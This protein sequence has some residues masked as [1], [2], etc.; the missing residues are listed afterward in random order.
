[1]T[2]TC[3]ARGSGLSSRPKK[4]IGSNSTPICSVP[5]T[6]DPTQS[7]PVQQGRRAGWP[8]R[9]HMHGS[10]AHHFVPHQS[11]RRKKMATSSSMMAATSYMRVNWMEMRRPR[12]CT[13]HPHG[14][15]GRQLSRN[16]GRGAAGAS[17]SVQAGAHRAATHLPRK[18]SPRCTMHQQQGTPT[19]LEAL[20]S[21]PLQPLPPLHPA[22]AAPPST[23]PVCWRGSPPGASGWQ[24]GPS[25]PSAAP[26][27]RA[28]QTPAA[29][30]WPQRCPGTPERHGLR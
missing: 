2:Q 9:S 19:E 26:T 12:S 30:G 22:E 25:T 8:W 7:Q 15:Q 3:Q 5:P 27:G 11:N 14:R 6:T 24:Y 18:H 20:G 29:A 4:R 13:H 17:P 1:M 28:T 21:T 10:S 16:S 23:A